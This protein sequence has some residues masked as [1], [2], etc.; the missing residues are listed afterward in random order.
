LITISIPEKMP[1]AEK[2]KLTPPAQKPPERPNT[3]GETPVPVSSGGHGEKSLTKVQ[4]SAPTHLESHVRR[5][6]KEIADTII[7]IV[8]SAA[9]DFSEDEMFALRSSFDD[10]VFSDLDELGLEPVLT[11][12]AEKSCKW[13]KFEP[14]DGVEEE[15]K[16]VAKSTALD[17]AQRMVAYKY[18]IGEVDSPELSEKA[19]K[20]LLREID[21]CDFAVL[22]SNFIQELD[23]FARKFIVKSAVLVIKENLLTNDD[24]DTIDDTVYHN[25]VE[26][27]QAKIVQHFDDIV[28]S[29][30]ELTMPNLMKQIE[31]EVINGRASK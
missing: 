2:K 22:T 30:F 25:I 31:T 3:L 28:H 20:K 16:E 17:T 18:E 7:P 12:L 26:S 24:I 10:A 5:T 1:E 27:S 9:R 21:K 11:G 4:F 29:A 6:V 19:K 23:V 13:V 15:L 14:V 8:L